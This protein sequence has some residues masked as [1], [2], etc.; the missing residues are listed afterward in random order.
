MKLEK[1]SRL[2]V[3]AL[4]AVTI[5]LTPV[6]AALGGAWSSSI[7]NGSADVAAKLGSIEKTLDDKRKELGVPGLSLVIVK[8]M[9]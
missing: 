2:I 5:G 8:L 9:V 1:P 4:L 7:Q 6:F 3:A